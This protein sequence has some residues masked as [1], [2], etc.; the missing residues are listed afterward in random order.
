MIGH[1]L[2]ESASYVHGGVCRPCGTPPR[3]APTSMASLLALPLTPPHPQTHPNPSAYFHYCD[4]AFF[5]PFFALAAYVLLPLAARLPF[6][7]LLLLLAAAA[8]VGSWLF[9]TRLAGVTAA[10]V[11]AS[12]SFLSFIATCEVAYPL[13]YGTH[14]APRWHGGR[15]LGSVV[16]LVGMCALPLLHAAAAWSDPGYVVAEEEQEGSKGAGGEQGEAGGGQGGKEGEAGDVE[17]GSGAEGRGQRQGGSAGGRG[18]EV[19]G[20]G[21][22]GP[23]LLLPLAQCSTCRVAK[24]LRSKHC[25]FCNKCVRR[26]GKWCWELAGN[27]L[28]VRAVTGLALSWLLCLPPLPVV[29]VVLAPLRASSTVCTSSSVK[30]YLFSP[31]PSPPDHH[32]PAIGNC[33]GEANERVFAAWLLVMVGVG[34][35]W[36]CG[37]RSGD[38]A[39]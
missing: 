6:P 34:P 30:E 39:C 2:P 4:L 35:E 25:Q 17:G 28:S 33:V 32:C 7:L 18:T 3:L 19:A 9:A 29:T 16:L 37:C 12:R 5:P 15:G 38:H 8:A 20:A 31:S 11:Q 10:R 13:V 26:F 24:P 27:M 22:A 1:V 14:V 23:R 36:G 21:E